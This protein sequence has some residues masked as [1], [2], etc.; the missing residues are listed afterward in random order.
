MGKRGQRGRN[1][2]PPVP[3]RAHRRVLLTI[4]AF[5]TLWFVLLG[6][7]L[8]HV[9]VLSHERLLARGQQMWNSTDMIRAPRG[10]LR[11]A[12]GVVL[13]RDVFSYEVGLDPSLITSEENLV[14]AIRVICDE[15]GYRAEKRRGH[16][17][18]ALKVKRAGRRYVRLGRRVEEELAGRIDR[19]VR[20]ALPKK[21]WPAF[22]RLPGSHRQY[23]RKEF[24]CHVVGVTDVDGRGLEGLELT[25]DP[26]LAQRAGKRQVVRSAVPGLRVFLPENSDIAAVNGSDIILTIDSRSQRILEDELRKGIERHRAEAGLGIIMNCQSGAILAMASW[27]TFDPGAFHRYPREEQDRRRKNRVIESS[28]EPGSVLKP[29]ILCAALSHGLIRRDERIWS[30]GKTHVFHL[31]GHP[32]RVRDT[33]DH[34]PLSAEEAVI[35]SSNIGMSFIGLR[36]GRD[37]LIELLER[38]GFLRRTE[39]RLPGEATG[40]RTEREAWR[41]LWTSIS[42]SFGYELR[43]TPIQLCTAFAALINGGKLYRPQLVDRILVDGKVLATYSP[44]LVDRPF[45]EDI[46]RQMREILLR[47]ITEGTGRSLEMEGFH[48]GGKTGTAD[49]GPRYKKEDYLASFEAFAPYE[50]PEV[51]VLVM[52]EKPRA[53]KY[54]GS[55]VA[56]PV[57]AG[58]LRRYFRVEAAPRFARN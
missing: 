4:L 29:F 23:P 32:R 58:V 27:P 33:S 19:A 45:D 46:S 3:A 51:V 21:E 30:G 12:D 25:M 55:Q 24:L 22:R 49:M 48:F 10:D 6:V 13:A 37:R 7:R 28:F 14:K 18:H 8:F 16:L 1:L 31:G 43:A 47:V 5:L 2:Q 53:G 57:V 26:F 38:C 44:E 17:R 11:L 52:I 56:G 40:V 39:I 34:N 50:D 9:Q 15:L 35:F 36:L 20:E 41:E 42:V 54:Y